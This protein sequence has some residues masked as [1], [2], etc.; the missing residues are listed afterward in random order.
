[1]LWASFLVR[2]LASV[3]L[4]VLISALLPITSS[5][6]ATAPKIAVIY[7]VGGRGDGGTDDAAALGVDQAKKKFGLNQFS[8]RE[9][10]TLG[11]EFDRENR[12]E[13][14]VKSGYQLV[15][16]VGPNF[17]LAMRTIASK[18]PES[19]Y[20]I[21]DNGDIDIISVSA[22]AFREDQGSFLA[23]VLA[24]LSSKSGKIAFIGES[25]NAV[26]Q[27]DE[28]NFLAGAKATKPKII[29]FSKNE[30]SGIGASVVGLSK[31]GVDVIFSNW[32]KSGEVLTAIIAQN[33][34]KRS[35]K[36]IGVAPDQF[37]LK[38]K[39][40]APYV[41]GYV[42]KSYQKAVFD[43]ITGA[44]NNQSLSDVVDADLGVYGRSYNFSNGGTSFVSLNPTS[45]ISSKISE[46]KK[47][48]ISGGIKTWKK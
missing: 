42:N 45:A 18:F 34:A 20:A 39:V 25:Y 8:L 21:V 24:A 5:F 3:L 16:A 32:S 36:F 40:A 38:S 48:L 2:K 14:A 13:F 19:Q 47:L 17:K 46:V 31:A 12:I 41:I 7:D 37:F 43:V 23:G 4:L 35:L 26:A 29:T 44:V 1:M 11:T 27:S 28:A 10:V 15:L 6:A 30:V 22:L 9:F 33:K